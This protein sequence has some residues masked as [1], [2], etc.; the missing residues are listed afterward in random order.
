MCS[1]EKYV[2]EITIPMKQEYKIW[3]ALILMGVDINDEEIAFLDY[4]ILHKS[5][6]KGLYSDIL[7]VASDNDIIQLEKM[8]LKL[9]A[10]CVDI[11]IIDVY[12]EEED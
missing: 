6:F 1:A 8:L 3:Q 7:Y 11:Y 10:D 5:L 12:E 2:W 4:T 9:K